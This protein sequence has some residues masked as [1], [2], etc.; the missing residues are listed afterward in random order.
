MREF[1]QYVDGIREDL[2]GAWAPERREA[3]R[4]RALL[5]HCL[6]YSSWR[7]LNDEGLSDAQMADLAVVWLQCLAAE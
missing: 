3:K 2:F 5:G 7:S 1:E 4:A 6:G